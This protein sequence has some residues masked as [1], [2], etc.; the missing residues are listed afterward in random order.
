[1]AIHFHYAG[2]VGQ[3]FCARCGLELTDAASMEAGIGPICRKMDN[4]LLAKLYPSN[5]VAALEAYKGIDPLA[6][7]ESTLNTFTGLESALIAPDAPARE[8]WRKPVKQIE[9]LLSWIANPSTERNK[10][11]DIVDALGYPALTAMWAGEAASGEATCRF[12][13]GRIYVKGPKNKGARI[14]LKSV[15]G[16]WFHAQTKEWSAPVTQ[17]DAFAA[18][19]AKHYPNNTGL[20]EA[21]AEAKQYIVNQEAV[22]KEFHPE[23]LPVQPEPEPEP[24]YTLTTNDDG[25]LEVKTPYKAEYIAELKQ[26]PY[27]SRMWNPVLK[28]WIV[29]AAYKAH[30]ESLL[31]KHFANASKAA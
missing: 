21:V 11:S 23:P 1:M 2:H 24:L 3:R 16:V 5:I 7:P 15:P 9:W 30:V 22:A 13:T 20:A 18:K 29:D 14:A 12:A 17:V 27:K 10:F 25:A 28:V 19:I 6:L 4:A 26:L 8:D 31:A